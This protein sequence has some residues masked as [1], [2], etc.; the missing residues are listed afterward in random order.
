MTTTAAAAAAADFQQAGKETKQD[1][2]HRDGEDLPRPKKKKSKR[3]ASAKKKKTTL[4]EKDAA[5]DSEA[6][7]EG[8]ADSGEVHDTLTNS[9]KRKTGKKRNSSKKLALETAK[10]NEIFGENTDAEAPSVPEENDKASGSPKPKS[11]KKKR[12]SSKTLEAATEPKEITEVDPEHERGRS[13]SPRRTSSKRISK[14]KSNAT[15]AAGAAAA[16]PVENGEEYQ[17]YS[18]TKH[19]TSKKKRSKSA[20][21]RK[22]KSV[23]VREESS[24]EV[25]DPSLSASDDLANN[26]PPRKWYDYNVPPSE[27][28]L[29]LN[30]FLQRESKRLARCP[31][32]YFWTALVIS[33]I[34]SFIALVVGEFEVSAETGGWQSRGTLIADRQQQTMMATAFN[35]Y[36]FYGGVEA[37]DDLTQNVQPGWESLDEFSDDDTADSDA[38]RR[39]LWKA[40]APS[41]GL[42][43]EGFTGTA[44]L[45]QTQRKHLPFTMTKAL[46]RRLQEAAANSTATGGLAG[47]LAGCDISFY[48]IPV[49]AED[50]RL[51]PVWSVKDPS[52][53]ALDASVVRDL[54]VAEQN[55]QTY[56]EE[57]GL[58]Y[59]CDNG[60]CLPPYSLVFY[61]R[62]VTE[63]GFQLDCDALAADWEPKQ[64]A[65]K[66]SWKNCVETIKATYDPNEEELP[67]NCPF[68]FYPSLV[69]GDFDETM[70]SSVTSTIFATQEA[71]VDEL[72]ENLDAYDRG[73]ATIE[74]AYETQYE[75]FSGIYLDSMLGRDMS[76]AL[77]SAF[78]V[79]IAIIVHTRSPL[80][81]GVGLL[82]IILSF[83]LSFFVYKLVA[84]LDFFP[85]LNFIG[86]FVVFA[87]GAGDIFVAIDKWK[88]ARISF[89]SHTYSTE[90]IA[91]K[92]LPDA[93][94]AM[95]LTTLT[96][97][98]AFFATAICPVAPIKM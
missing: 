82:Q 23:T 83:P 62:L 54:C 71:A 81:T 39:L 80:I 5:D 90:F 28:A 31:C 32:T 89:P 30:S 68:G 61:A 52:A 1:E 7:A 49:T 6:Q 44:S 2:D 41:S 56:L 65:V 33:V 88:N 22:S 79:A 74:G 18:S 42:A 9:R 38:R 43:V 16:V 53:S 13:A 55:T 14:K 17:P 11:K 3:K 67:E 19:N 92:A 15:E 27:D 69:D 66:E 97:A 78:V 46:K 63:N 47:Q 95:L 20:S 87:L 50:S 48:D 75:D 96:T 25:L 94:Y 57:N 91:A 98:V 76:L 93:A 51:W 24:T 8:R 58:C 29:H 70:L 45:Q 73:T 4:N 34:L 10:G 85:F 84:G 35:E 40:M 86:I 77:G 21:K 12:K 59:G 36:L 60:K 72:Y 37:W 26:L 64:A